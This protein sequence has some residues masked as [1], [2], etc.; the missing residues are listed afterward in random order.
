MINQHIIDT[1]NARHQAKNSRHILTQKEIM[2]EHS[3]FEQHIEGL[4]EDAHQSVADNQ[5]RKGWNSVNQNK[6]TDVLQGIVRRR[7]IRKYER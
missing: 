1:L 2:K 4:A 6:R 3:N 5:G 7:N